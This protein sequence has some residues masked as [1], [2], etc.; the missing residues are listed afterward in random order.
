MKTYA[1]KVGFMG[2][3]RDRVVYPKDYIIKA[4][5]EEQAE[6]SAFNGLSMQEYHNIKV[7]EVKEI[8]YEH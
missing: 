6:A 8:S 3:K 4:E 5:S 2:D 1:V 7:L